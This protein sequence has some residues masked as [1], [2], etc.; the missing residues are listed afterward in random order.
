MDINTNKIILIINGQEYSQFS[1]ISIKRNIEAIASSF[2]FVA[3]NEFSE[4][5]PFHAFDDCVVKVNEKDVL[6][7]YVTFLRPV[8]SNM[9]HSINII[10]YDNTKDVADT[11]IY[12]NSQI[13]EAK[14]FKSLIEDMLTSHGIT[15]IGVID[16]VGNLE[17]GE[18]D[19][20]IASETGSSLYEYFMSIAKKKQVL[21]STD[22]LSNIVIYRNESP[23]KTNL[24]LR[25]IRGKSN[26]TIKS[27]SCTFDYNKRFK[28]IKVRSQDGADT[29]IRG[30]SVDTNI[31]R[32]RTKTIISEL[33]FN[34]DECKKLADWE[35][36]NRRL[37]SIIYKCVVAGFWAKENT[38]FAPN[39][40]YNI[41]D[42]Y[43]GLK[44]TML[45]KEVEYSY[46]NISGSVS[47]LT[48][49]AKDA[50]TLAPNPLKVT[51]DL[52]GNFA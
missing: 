9:D 43:C 4:D 34:A 45:L 6:T 36:N 39:Q 29:D 35:V 50:Y 21:L 32:E 3:S 12:N 47:S 26:E 51:D 41:E 30:E 16:A 42:D 13:T 40:F 19:L 8:Y 11:D 20:Y 49:V 33:V 44:K 24:S 22:G 2:E 28:T 37:N 15:G 52:G 46:S 38:I 10:G 48:F 14:S 1:E 31:S 7:G 17:L 27:A 5:F 23:D 18:D 25:N